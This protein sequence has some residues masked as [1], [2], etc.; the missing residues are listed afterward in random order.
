[1]GK[2]L[3]NRAK[4]LPGNRELREGTS[5]APGGDW[6]AGDLGC[7]RCTCLVRSFEGAGYPPLREVKEVEDIQVRGFFLQNSGGCTLEV[8]Q[9]LDPEVAAVSM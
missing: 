7:G 5:P 1:M 9:L 8:Q 4:R 3:L 6:G 2:D